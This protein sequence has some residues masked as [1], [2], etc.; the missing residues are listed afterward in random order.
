M[1]KED[2]KISW[3]TEKKITERN[4]KRGKDIFCLGAFSYYVMRKG[5]E[6]F[7]MLMLDYE[8]EGRGF[9]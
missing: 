1:G 4:N 6:I 5:E 7:K 3:K 8:G 2:E 9:P